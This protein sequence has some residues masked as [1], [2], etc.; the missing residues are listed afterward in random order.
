VTFPKDT[1]VTAVTVQGRGD[2][3]IPQWIKSYY[4]LYSMD[5][6]TWTYVMSPDGSQK[7]F[8]GNT[9]QNTPVT[10]L[11]TF[12]VTV[13]H[14]RINPRT[15]YRHISLRFDVS[16][17]SIRKRKDGFSHFVM[18]PVTEENE[19]ITSHTVIPADSTVRSRAECGLK[20][21]SHSTCMSFNYTTSNGVQWCTGYNAWIVVPGQI[22]SSISLFVIQD[23]LDLYGYKEDKE[24]A[25]LYN[26]IEIRKTQADAATSCTAMYTRLMKVDKASKMASL[27]NTVSG[28]LVLKHDFRFY[29]AGVYSPPTWRYIEEETDE[30]DSTLWSPGN[31]NPGQGHCVMLTEAG[32]TSVD[33]E[34][35]LFSICGN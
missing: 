33:C 11:L 27:Q 29:V 7:L 22:T 35:R 31:P 4:L 3:D 14:L 5:S 23:V 8:T 18:K 19:M 2:P 16:G 30:I 21:Q 25:I 15:W 10:S 32:L 9:D 24:A 28:Y 26:I 17:C 12:N 20:C 34:Q 13:R 6:V 1:I